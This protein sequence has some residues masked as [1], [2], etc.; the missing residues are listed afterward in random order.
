MDTNIIHARCSMLLAEDIVLFLKSRY[1]I[2]V[3]KEQV[4][5]TILEGLAAASVG[6]DGAINNQ[7]SSS[8]L[9]LMEIMAILLI[10]TLL[11]ASMSCEE[12]SDGVI[13]PR[14]GII[15]YVLSMVLHDASSIIGV[16]F[17]YFVV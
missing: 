10:P 7:E 5:A 16:L 3:R 14:S 11:K 2:D 4:Q 13:A 1:G 17:C 15:D 12:L 8:C 9:D 6:D